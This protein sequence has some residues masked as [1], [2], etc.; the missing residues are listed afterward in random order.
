LPRTDF[1]DAGYADQKRKS[2]PQQLIRLNE[3]HRLAAHLRQAPQQRRLRLFQI[4]KQRARRGGRARGDVQAIFHLRQL[5]DQ[6]LDV[7]AKAFDSPRRA[8]RAVADL[9][10]KLNQGWPKVLTALPPKREIIL[11]PLNARYK[12]V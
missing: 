10:Y 7:A 3:L 9:R 5:V 2:L 6:R 12:V 1:R 8:N 11:T 4:D